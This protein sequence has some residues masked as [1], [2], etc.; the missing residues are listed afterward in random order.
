MSNTYKELPPLVDSSLVERAAKLSTA[1][2]CDGMTTLK[3][4]RS[5][6]MDAAIMPVDPSMKVVGTAATVETSVGDN[7]P[8]HVAIYSCKPDYVLLVDGK[9][10]TERAYMGDLMAG[11]ADA[12]GIK[13]VVVDGYVRDLEGLKEIGM[14]IYA[15]GIMQR[16]PDKIGPGSINMPIQC[17]GVMVH[18]GDLVVGDYDGVVVIPRDKIEAVLE[19]AEAKLD[20][21]QQR[22]DSIELYRKSRER[23]EAL[24]T[25]TPAWVTKMLEEA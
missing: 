11:S 20:Y 25:L 3:I 22:R 16:T 7:L 15:R 4:E 13:G 9:A 6:C 2:L 21:E 19:A 17:G 24:P 5:G 14:P 10:Y 1:E 8:I 23:G 12:I 18:P